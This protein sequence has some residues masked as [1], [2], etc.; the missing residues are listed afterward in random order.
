MLHVALRLKLI[1]EASYNELI[2]NSYKRYITS[3]ISLPRRPGPAAL[4]GAKDWNFK[5][6]TSKPPREAVQ[7]INLM[8][9]LSLE[10]K[11]KN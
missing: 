5:T 11:S 4:G 3:R 9:I 6:E 8:Y 1:T 2:F 7:N 10:D